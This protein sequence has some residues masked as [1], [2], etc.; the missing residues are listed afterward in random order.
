MRQVGQL[1]RI[2]DDYVKELKVRIQAARAIAR[3]RLLKSK[4][5]SKLDYDGK[6]VQ[7]ALKVGDRVLLFDE[8]VR[9]GR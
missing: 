4:S 3:S 1:P 7:I 6:T 2:I 5:K 9:R 8:S